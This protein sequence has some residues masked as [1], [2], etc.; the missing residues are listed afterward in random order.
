MEPAD[1]RELQ[2]TNRSLLWDLTAAVPTSL[3]GSVV[4]WGTTLVN[5]CRIRA[6]QWERK[7]SAGNRQFT[8]S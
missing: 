7:T 1:V 8:L 2:D 4:A 5:A 3:A 6:S